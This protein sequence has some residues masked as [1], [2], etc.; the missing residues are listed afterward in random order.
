MPASAGAPRC[1]TMPAS[2]PNRVEWL[3][4]NPLDGTILV[5]VPAGKF[6]AGAVGLDDVAFDVDVVACR[7]DG[8]EHGLEGLRT[9]LQQLDP[10][11]LEHGLAEP[12]HQFMGM[13]MPRRHGRPQG[14]VGEAHR[15]GP[16]KSGS[17]GN[18]VRGSEQTVCL[19]R[20]CAAGPLEG[21]RPAVPHDHPAGRRSPK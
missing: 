16:G 11:A 13:G 14:S 8:P 17:R 6:F 20:P 18:R 12:P 5:L 9:I 4:E 2:T 1:P 19:A 10:V 7:I 21:E 15:V 3:V